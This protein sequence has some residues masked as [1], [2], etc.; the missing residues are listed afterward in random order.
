MIVD[1]SQV[2]LRL[3]KR[4]IQIAFGELIVDSNI[5]FSNDGLEAID[6]YLKLIQSGSIT[7]FMYAY[8]ISLI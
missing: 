6:H 5:R 3:T 8:I 4:K 1:D 7:V 2:N